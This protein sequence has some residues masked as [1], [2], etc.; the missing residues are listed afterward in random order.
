MSNINF[1]YM[2]IHSN[3]IMVSSCSFVLFVVESL[4]AAGANSHSYRPLIKSFIHIIM[5]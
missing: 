5:R 1:R 3:F 4:Y 2:P